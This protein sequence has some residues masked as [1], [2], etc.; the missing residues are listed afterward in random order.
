MLPA[1]QDGRAVER[2]KPSPGAA[3]TATPSDARRC[4]RAAQSS[5]DGR[6]R[7]SQSGGGTYSRRYSPARPRELIGLSR[8][9]TFE[10]PVIGD[11]AP[12]GGSSDAFL[13][14]YL[15]RKP[16]LPAAGAPALIAPPVPSQPTDRDQRQG[17]RCAPGRLRHARRQSGDLGTSR[18]SIRISR[19]GR[20]GARN[21][22]SLL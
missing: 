13:V 9:F 17:A 18:P 22:I 8:F 6:R 1:R 20:R 12:G 16:G 2:R 4:A 14:V 5:R 15:N 7:L 21:A 3:K 19:V 11:K 10:T